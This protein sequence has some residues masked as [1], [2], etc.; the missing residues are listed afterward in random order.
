VGGEGK[1]ILP[2]LEPKVASLEDGT[3]PV[4]FGSFS[5]SFDSEDEGVCDSLLN[6]VL[7]T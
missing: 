1:T 5:F 6:V 4:W 2:F 3:V 7:S